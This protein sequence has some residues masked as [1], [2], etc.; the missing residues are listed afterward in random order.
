M[1]VA[2]RDV[3]DF[4]AKSPDG[5]A[6]LVMVEDRDWGFQGAL[7][8]EFQEKLNAYLGFAEE[9]LLVEYPQLAECPLHIQLRTAHAPGV[10]DR[11]FFE[12]VDQQVL[13][14]AGVKWSWQ[15]LRS[16]SDGA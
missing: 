12:L 15:L 5:E 11:E 9:Q 1:A 13:A 14:P 2:D 3:I 16:S 4:V 6:L 7:R 10:L 8:E